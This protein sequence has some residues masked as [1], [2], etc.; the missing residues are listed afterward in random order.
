M[1]GNDPNPTSKPPADENADDE[2]VG[3]GGEDNDF[4]DED[5]DADDELEDDEELDEVE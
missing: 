4:E 1:A 2:I 3:V 5:T